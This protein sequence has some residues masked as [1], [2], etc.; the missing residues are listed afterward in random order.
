MIETNPSV[1][2]E[3]VEPDFEVPAGSGGD[4]LDTFDESQ[5][6]Q[7]EYLFTGNYSNESSY[8]TPRG[9][10]FSSGFEIETEQSPQEAESGESDVLSAFNESEEYQLEYLFTGTYSN[11]SAYV[12]PRGVVS[13]GG[14][15]AG[16]TGPPERALTGLS[17]TDSVFDGVLYMV[18]DTDEPESI[19]PLE[20][21]EVRAIR[22][23]IPYTDT[24]DES[25]SFEV[26]LGDPGIYTLEVEHPLLGVIDGE[27]DISD[28][29]SVTD[30][31]LRLPVDAPGSVAGGAVGIQ[32]RSIG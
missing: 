2:T 1:E 30:E 20:G 4:D 10:V 23:G 22:E 24:T 21:A 13:S 18:D 29:G 9:V 8:P 19:H 6:E 7:L 27:V 31:E 11:E 28:G 14:Y 32:R 25:G 17:V 12:T 5:E 15:E 3:T 26:A 16:L